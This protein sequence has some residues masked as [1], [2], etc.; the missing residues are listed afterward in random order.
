MIMNKVETKQLGNSDMSI[1]P[2]G[3]GA[4][5]KAEIEAPNEVTA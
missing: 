1:T 2:V 4:W 5:E 3:F